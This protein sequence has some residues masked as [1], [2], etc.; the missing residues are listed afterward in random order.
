[1]TTPNKTRATALVPWSHAD[2]QGVLVHADSHKNEWVLPGGG[3]ELDANGRAETPRVAVVRELAE[4]TGLTA[5]AVATLFLYAGKFRVHHVFHIRPSGTLQIVDPKE[6]PAFGL[7]GP[8]L[9]VDMIA[10]AP[11]YST[12]GRTLS[13]SARAIIERYQADYHRLPSARL[14]PTA[15]TVTGERG[16]IT[17]S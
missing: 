13:H 4:E 16:E 17:Q 9:V 11:N 1:M 15:L 2:K 10:C 8:G 3:L 12:G 5:E 6:A 7:C 14:I